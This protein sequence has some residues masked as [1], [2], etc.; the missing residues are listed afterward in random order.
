M[1]NLLIILSASLLLLSCSRKGCPEAS[2]VISIRDSVVINDSVRLRDSVIIIPGQQLAFR[3]SI[4][5]IAG[6]HS[7]EAASGDSM[8]YDK[9]VKQGN[10][11]AHLDIDKKGNLNFFCKA[12]SLQKRI[13]WL[14]HLLSIQSYKTITEQVPGPVVKDWYI[15]TW[16]K[17]YIAITLGLVVFYFRDS[18]VKLIAHLITKW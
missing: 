10:M 2:R 18:I 6:E 8:L 5:W 15:P 11:S 4:L 1:R 14:E 16:I 9:T 13:E 7:N 3:D 12:D 17:W